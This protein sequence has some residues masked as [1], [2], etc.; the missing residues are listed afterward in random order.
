M[1]DQL[2]QQTAPSFSALFDQDI[3]VKLNGVVVATLRASVGEEEISESPNSA[4]IGSSVM[5]LTI[6]DPTV[7][8]TL[9]KEKLYVYVVAGVPMKRRGPALRDPGGVKLFM[10]K[11]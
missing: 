8:D 6:Q 3:P 11:A 7:Y 4:E 1:F 10:T 5:T 9:A 2:V